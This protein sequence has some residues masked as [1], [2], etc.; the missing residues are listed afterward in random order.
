[1]SGVRKGTVQ[2][3][4]PCTHWVIIV[5]KLVTWQSESGEVWAEG[6]A[7][8]NLPLMLGCCEPKSTL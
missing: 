4:S 2:R 6:S 3:G 5:V 1:M 7:H 8:E